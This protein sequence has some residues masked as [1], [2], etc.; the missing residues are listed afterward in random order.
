MGFSIGSANLG[1]QGSSAYAKSLEWSDIFVKFGYMV[2]TRK[3]TS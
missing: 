1:P 2:Y 3:L